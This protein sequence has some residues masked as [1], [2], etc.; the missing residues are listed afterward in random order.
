VEGILTALRITLCGL[1]AVIGLGAL[2]L[3]HDVHAWR[4]AIPDGDARFATHP[5]S[6]R[7]EA[8][9]WLPQE[10]ALRAL[11]V[12]DDLRLRRAEQS[13]A[14]SAGAKRGLDGGRR[15]SERRAATEVALADVVAVGSPAQASR[16]GNLLGILT[17]PAQDPGGA[18]ATFDAA[19]RADLA[20]VYAKHNLELLLRRIKVIGIHDGGGA[21]LGGD[22]GQALAGAG[23]GLSGSGY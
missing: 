6:A 11:G 22:Y 10:V 19:I 2:A 21:N 14:R 15:A 17:S 7:W 3:A 18:A 1:A 12:R 9:T 13:F 8:A 23:A 4:V 20:N 5:A 16:A